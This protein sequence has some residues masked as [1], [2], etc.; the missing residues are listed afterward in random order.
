M[1]DRLVFPAV[2]TLY[3]KPMLVIDTRLGVL[4]AAFH[5]SFNVNSPEGGV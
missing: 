4:D 1:P 3:A 5:S 2:A